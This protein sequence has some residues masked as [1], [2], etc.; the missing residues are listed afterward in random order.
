MSPDDV[1]SLTPGA[2]VRECLYLVLGEPLT[3]DTT[4]PDVTLIAWS[5]DV[6][7]QCSIRNAIAS[8]SVVTPTASEVL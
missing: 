7:A 6:V 2:I 1:T 8:A 3:A 4:T 5:A